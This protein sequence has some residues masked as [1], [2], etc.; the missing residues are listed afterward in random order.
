M[1]ARSRKTYPC[2]ESA[3]KDAALNVKRKS[4]TCFALE[5][6]ILEGGKRKNEEEKEKL[7]NII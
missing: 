4:V 5:P 1:R 7:F 2:R 6:I 3:K